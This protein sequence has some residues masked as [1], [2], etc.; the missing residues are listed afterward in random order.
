METYKRHKILQKLPIVPYNFT[1]S[2]KAKFALILFNGLILT[3]FFK[4]E[5]SLQTNFEF[6]S[7]IL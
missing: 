1:L 7:E 6:F 3:H 4:T 2:L 5:V